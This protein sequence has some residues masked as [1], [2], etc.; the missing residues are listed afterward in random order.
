MQVKQI[1]WV[2][3]LVHSIL[4]ASIEQDLKNFFDKVGMNSNINSAG[5]Y[6]DQSAGY[7]TGGSIVARSPVRNTQL[8]TLHIPGARGGCG[9]IDAWMGGF[10][11]IKTED[12][13]KMLRSI[14]SN[15]MSYAFLLSL[16]TVSPQIY[17]ILNE[18]NAIATKV[19]NL[20]INSCEAAATLLGGVWPKT[21]QSSRYLCQT[22]GSNL[23][24]FS[25]WAAA[26]QGCGVKGE[27]DNVLAHKARDSAYKDALVGEFNLSWIALQKRDFLRADQSIAELFMT[28][29]GSIVAKKIDK[30]YQINILTG[31]ADRD[32]LLSGLL[33]GGETQIYK[34]DEPS[35]CLNPSLRTVNIATNVA[36]VNRV[37][38]TLDNMIQKIYTDTELSN[39]EKNFL[40]STRLPVYK[41]LN[42]L[43]AYRSGSPAINVQEYSDLIAL[44]VLHKY[45]LEVIDVVY[46]SMVELKN[47]QVDDL[48]IKQFLNQLTA[49]RAQVYRRQQSAFQQMDTILSIVQATQLAEKQL[50]TML[51][52]VANETNWY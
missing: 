4:Q 43:V 37:K 40:N 41:M 3:L 2:L 6:Q 50:H 38:D 47:S 30:N 15:A 32:G 44:D 27:R 22:M 23:G 1:L 18:L 20:N 10:S 5:V 13:S 14:G 49:A 19:N 35:R 21:D 52:G 12:L 9:G 48:H 31:H 33:H 45:I 29:V 8:A 42:V 46:D 36:L 16:Q 11:H 39:E 7:Y 34:C 28:M 17:N 51:G 26:R 25:D 24:N